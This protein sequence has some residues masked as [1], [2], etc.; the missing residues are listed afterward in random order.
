VS[1]YEQRESERH[2]H[3]RAHAQDAE[4][5]TSEVCCVLPAREVL[6]ESIA[7]AGEVFDYD[8]MIYMPVLRDLVKPSEGLVI[9]DECQ[10]QSERER[11][12]ESECVCERERDF[13]E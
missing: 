10:V 8:D 6:Q 2:E 13:A 7:V 4:R 5:E 3:L 11:E 1:I 12:R 9:V